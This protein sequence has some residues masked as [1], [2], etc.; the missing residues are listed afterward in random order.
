MT[1][2][3][4]QARPTGASRSVVVIGEA[5]VDIVE[6]GGRSTEHVGGSPANVALGL[7]RLGRHVTFLTQIGDDPRG[8]R[9]GAHLAESE[10]FVRS[11][12]VGGST[13]SATARIQPGGHAVYDFDIAWDSF[14]VR[15]L[16]PTRIIHTGSIAAFLEPGAADVRDLLRLRAGAMVTFD[17]NIRPALVGPREGALRVFEKTARMCTVI[18]MSDEDADYLYPGADVDGVLDILL[19]FGAQLAVMTNGARGAVLASGQDRV[20]IGASPV[21]VVDT[22][23]AG[24]TFMVSLID[25]LLDAP[26]AG[27]EQLAEMGRKAARLASVTVSRAGADLPWADE[28]PTRSIATTDRPAPASR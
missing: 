6:D 19:S 25:S 21:D 12:V 24:D 20:R 3:S 7:G 8:A 28:A 2:A 22:I 1:A 13:S 9:I 23:G 10:V 5:L 4:G 16:P 27:A 26:P 14:T 18:K 11:L 17:P 15:A